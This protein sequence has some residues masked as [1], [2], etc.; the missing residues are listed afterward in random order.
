MKTKSRLRCSSLALIGMLLVSNLS[1]SA[2]AQSQA[3]SGSIEGSITDS[4][5]AVVPDAKVLARNKQTGLTREAMSNDEGLYRLPLLPVGDYDLTIDK[6]GFASVKREGVKIEVGQKLALDIQLGAAGAAE[7]INVTAEAP[8]VETTRTQVS[9]TVNERAVANLP[10]N[11]RNFIDFVLLTPGVTLDRTRS[12]DISF[13]GQRG[14]LNSLQID[15]ADNNNTFFGQTLGRTGS[16]RAPYQFS[17]DAVQ[18]FQVNSNGYSAEFG[19]A[20]GAVINVVTKS[21]GNQFHGTLFEFYRD[22][23][24]NANTT[25][26]NAAGRDAAGKERRPRLA[27]VAHQFGGNVSGP[28][29]KDRAFFFFDYD[30]QRRQDPIDVVL[31]GTRVASTDPNFAAQQAALAQIA[32]RAG[33]YAR[34]LNQNVYLFKGDWQ[35]SRSNHLTGRYNRQNFTGVAQENSAATGIPTTNSTL[36]HSGSSL[37][38]TDT[39]TFSLSSV[40]S[41]RTVNEARFQWARDQEPGTANSDEPETIILQ[42]GTVVQLGRNNFSPRETTEKRYQFIDN[43]SYALGRHGLKAGVD[44][45]IENILNFFPGLFSGSYTFN[46]LAD[47]TNRKPAFFQQSFPG[48]GT[49]GPTTN[50]D[51]REF[52]AFVQDDWRVSPRLTVNLGLRYDIQKMK[53]PEITNP[54]PG[55]AALGI[56]TSQ[57][58]LDQNNYAPRFGFAWNPLKSEKMVVRGGYGIFFARTPAIM[59]ATATSNNGIQVINVRFTG[60]AMPTYPARFSSLPSGGTPGAPSIYVFAADY[61]SPYIQQWNLGTE[62]QLF[63]NTSVT[64]SYLGVKGTHVQRTR[65]INLLPPVPVTV[66]DLTGNNYTFLR[67]PGRRLTNFARISLF[68]STANSIYHGLTVQVNKRFSQSFQM[69]AAYTFSRGIDDVPDATSVVIGADDSKIVQNTLNNRDDRGLASAD[70]RNRFVLSGVWD[71]SGYTKGIGNPVVRAALTGWSFA[72]IFTAEDGRPYSARVGSDINNDGNSATDRV[73]AVGRNTFTSPGF[74]SF[75]PRVTREIRF[76]ER[77]RLQL[78]VE[79]FNAFNRVNFDRIQNVMFNTTGTFPNQKLTVAPGF[80]TATTSL[81][82]RNIQLAA[83]IVF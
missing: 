16:G 2:I 80:G 82:P 35:V 63:R 31:G 52:S 78:I 34:L 48:A 39:L 18:E 28:I 10:A 7:S 74:V 79:A 32:P 72:A 67:F 11:G 19:R 65:D 37:V 38:T 71:L 81:N 9:A 17:Q 68:D 62:Y 41:S 53:R 64:L 3:A 40:L 13:A 57:V 50:P 75:D 49:T 21:G 59:L 83:K 55:L 60:A 61:V 14:T 43:I 26:N 33:S 44:V 73:P 30:G 36:E 22:K 69:M 29:V 12:G 24:L 25:F 51:I 6:Q 1:A 27:L 5:G 15:G 20:G 46:S 58:N 45:N 42:G 4:T 77:A 70:V 66:Q 54:D 8:V 56:N 23:A 76:Y 47:F